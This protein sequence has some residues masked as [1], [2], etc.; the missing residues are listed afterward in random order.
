MKLKKITLLIISI[1]LVS[2]F[3]FNDKGIIKSKTQD[4]FVNAIVE[5][6]IDLT[7]PDIIEIIY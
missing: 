3:I 4:Y 1:I 2:I 7:P 5:E 6:N